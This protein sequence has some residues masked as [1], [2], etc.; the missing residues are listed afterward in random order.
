MKDLINF[1]LPLNK[2][3]NIKVIGVGGGGG[4][5]VSYMHKCGIHGVDFFVCNT[6]A[7]ALD[8]SPVQN[9]IQL[10][11]GLGAGGDPSVAEKEAIEKAGEIKEMLENNAQMVF[12]TAGMGGGTGTGASPVIARILKEM[13]IKDKAIKNILVV[14]I[15]TTPFSF[16]G[17]ERM[18]QALGGIA[19]LRKHVDAIIIVDNDNLTKYGEFKM[20]QA[21]AFA[22][23]ILSSAVKSIAEIVTVHSTVQIDIRDVNTVMQNSGVALMGFGI[24]EGKDRAINAIKQAVESPLLS[25]SNTEGAKNVLLN[26]SSSEENEMTMSE[27][28]E[29]TKF[30]KEATGSSVNIIWGAGNNNTL[31]EKIAI[32]FVA[33]GFSETNPFPIPKNDLYVESDNGPFSAGGENKDEVDSTSNQNIQQINEQSEER[34]N[35]LRELN[36]KVKSSKVW[37]NSK[38]SLLMSVVM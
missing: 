38:E 36:A 16:E 23:E 35:H 5:A 37:K 11:E 28:E 18:K 34:I 7:S 33:T 29:I 19:E 22:N 25:N 26:I 4:N 6:D 20:T 8:A 2:S 31:G 21:F 9:K 13:E 10:G 24:A 30:V 27:F 1:D 15:V 12:I 32:T 3:S 14:A 17:S